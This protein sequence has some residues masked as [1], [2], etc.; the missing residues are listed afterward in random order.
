MLPEDFRRFGH[1]VVDWIAGYLAHPEKYPV[2]PKVS[3]GELIDALPAAGPETGEP[4]E[5]IL[6]DFEKLIV[7][8]M[9]HW[10]HPGFMA[11][12]ANSSPGPAILAEMLAAALNGNG[13]LWKTSPAVTELEQVTLGWLRQWMDLPG[14]WFGMIHDTASTSTMHAIAGARELADPEVRRRGGSHNLVVYTSEQSHS[15]VEKGA[16]SLGIGQE[17]V[18]HIAVDAEFRMRPEALEEA[19]RRD[20][21]A[22]LKPIFVA[23]PVPPSLADRLPT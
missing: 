19:I 18:R 16:I 4:M 3:P 6:G 9:T 1:E 20:R 13:M 8:G 10:N 15:S 23:E 11:Y 2:V 14:D 5:R 12:F 21:D 7:P 22:G 17:N